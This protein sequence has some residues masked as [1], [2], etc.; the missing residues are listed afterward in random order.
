MTRHV[1]GGSCCFP[2]HGL[3]LIGSQIPSPLPRQSPCASAWPQCHAIAPCAPSAL[4]C[5]SR[6]LPQAPPLHRCCA[7]GS[8]GGANDDSDIN[9]P[10]D[11][12]I[13][14]NSTSVRQLLL[15]GRPTARLSLSHPSSSMSQARS[16][17]T[18]RGTSLTTAPGSTQTYLGCTSGSSV[19]PVRTDSST[20]AWIWMS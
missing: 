14:L 5:C 10:T 4:C 12:I 2:R 16:C 7:L 17:S 8:E 20:V 15:R 3:S 1:L 6:T 9:N 19:V 11:S 18:S 13:D